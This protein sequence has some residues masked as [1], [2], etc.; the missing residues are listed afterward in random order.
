MVG[1]IAWQ[2]LYPVTFFSGFQT[3]VSSPCGDAFV[4]AVVTESALYVL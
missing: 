1:P 3:L 2:L 4:I